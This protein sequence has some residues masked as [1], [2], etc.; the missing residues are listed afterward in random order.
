MINVR[1]AAD[2]HVLQTLVQSNHETPTSKNVD[3]T[4]AVEGGAEL[5]K[6]ALRSVTGCV[7]ISRDTSKGITNEE[8][9]NRS[10]TSVFPLTDGEN[11]SNEHQGLQADARNA[12]FPYESSNS[13]DDDSILQVRHGIQTNV[14][15]ISCTN[16]LNGIVISQ[17]LSSIDNLTRIAN[18]S[19]TAL[20]T[21]SSSRG[22]TDRRGAG[23]SGGVAARRA[24]GPRGGVAA[25]RAVGPRRGVTARRA[26]GPRRG[27]SARRSR[28]KRS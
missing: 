27:V 17:P 16:P 26:V 22:A 5:Q 20:R 24:V 9:R 1:P 19:V 10:R 15:G 7:A 6:L 18:S 13:G 14:E 28:S 8:A 11:G 12:L 3:V 21:T 2:D 4:N 23:P 25:R